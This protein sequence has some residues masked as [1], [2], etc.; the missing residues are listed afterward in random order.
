MDVG[1][2][3]L[4]FWTT[5]F[6]CGTFPCLP[7]EGVK[8]LAQVN[9]PTPSLNDGT[10]G[11]GHAVRGGALADV[12]PFPGRLAGTRWVRARALVGPARER[13]RQQ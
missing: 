13:R 1:W 9:L 8:P 6:G 2:M 5:S 11:R 10:W 4:R 12:T 3:E 7:S